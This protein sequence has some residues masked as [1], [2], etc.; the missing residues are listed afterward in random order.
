MWAPNADRVDLVIEDRAVVLATGDRGY[1]RAVVDGVA[2]GARYA[3]RLEDGG[4]ERPDPASRLQPDG[5]HGRSAVVDPA[6]FERHHAWRGLSLEAYVIY[7]LHVGTFSEEGTFDGAIDH[8]DHLVDLGVTAAEIMPV[9]QFPGARNWGYDGVQPFAAHT[10]YGGPEGLARLVTACH[11]RGLAVVLD[12]VYNHMGPEG[13]YLRDFGPYFT[14]RYTTPWGSAMNLDDSGSDEVRRYFIENALYWLRDVGFDALRLDAVH[15][16]FDMSAKPFLLELSETTA[17]LVQEVGRPLYLIAESDL[18]DIRVLN[19]AERG[20]FGMD[21]QWSDD[22][23]HSV[24]ALL[25]GE[26]DGY[27]R[28]F[29]SFEDLETAVRDEFVYAGRYSEHRG[30]RHGN[31]A[32]G[33]SG[34]RFVHAIQNHDQVGNRMLGDRLSTVVPPEAA[35][36][37]AALLLLTPGIPLLFMGEEY[38]EAAPFPYFVSHGD[39]ELVEAVRQGRRREFA[40][41]GWQGEVPDPQAEETFLSAKLR[42]D[43]LGEP[44][45]EEMLHLYRELLRLRREVPALALQDRERMEVSRFERCLVVTRSDGNDGRALVAFNLGHDPVKVDLPEGVWEQILPS[46][47]A[48]ETTA[49][50][51]E[52]AAMSFV[53]LT[54]RAVAD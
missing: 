30:R 53:V 4:A 13:N 19:P 8:L 42:W 9:A 25:T 45:H 35:R 6:V 46:S 12:V 37:A 23:H 3:F 29:G 49:G 5:V 39:P 18:N 32:A 50:A 10:S 26:R 51:V 47:P 17:E 33:M 7:E 20:G 40:S 28:D 15:G 52:V 34:S 48:G 43:S 16:I 21:A 1:H 41:F 24:H 31:S 27:Y 54:S 11:R 36:L 14:D 2:N 44:D 38:G 22:F